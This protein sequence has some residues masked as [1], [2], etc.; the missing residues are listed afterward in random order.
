MTIIIALLSFFSLTANAKILLPQI[1]SSNMVLQRDKPINIWGFAAE[2]EKIEVSF[3]GQKKQTVTDKN[4]NWAVALNPLKTSAMPQTM[5]ISGSNKI[6]LTNILVGEVWLCSGQSNMEYAMR[7][8]AKIPKPKNDKLGFPADEVAKANNSQIRIFLVNR[9]TLGKPDSVHK[10]W[11]VAQDSALKAF[12]AVGYFFAKE[13]QQKLG[14]PVGVIS[15]AVP[16][17][18]IEPWISQEAFATERYF[19]NEK[20]GNDP[21]KFYIPMIEPLTKFKIN[22]F[23]WYQGETNCFLNENISYAYKMKT[24]INLWRKA[25]GENNLPFYYV[26]IAPFDYSKQKSDKVV[27]TADTEPAFWEA[28]E[29]IL[30]L[31]NTGMISTSDLKD[32]GGDLHPT[33]KWEVGRRLAL[34]A[35]G[36]TYNQKIDFSGPILKK[37]RI[38]L[39]YV[40]LSFDYLKYYVSH[41]MDEF[42]G[43]EIAGKDGKFIKAQA[44]RKGTEVIVFSKEITRPKSV[45]YNWTENPSG[46]FYGNGLPALPFRTDNP[47]TSTFKPN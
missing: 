37:K 29:Q 14:V 36:K 15:S 38:Y 10:S 26:Q 13:L 44:F 19:K 43:F 8:L 7:K 5:T 35:L 34:L 6:E 42:T 46:N 4:G 33:Y 11:S 20:V 28:Q 1:L 40:I 27:L 32:N 2:G 30:R 12:S 21:G 45:R 24:M 41:N 23:L 22:G 18:A 16:G 47:L 25:W 9:K 31:P 3:A 39:Q 17:S